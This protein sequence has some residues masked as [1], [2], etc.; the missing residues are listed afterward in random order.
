M[1][2]SFQ[3]MLAGK[4]DLLL[5][6]FPVYVSAKLD[7]VRITIR[8]Q[9]PLTRKLKQVPNDH[10]RNTLRTMKLPDLDGE[11]IVG[12]ATAKDCFNCTQ[13]AVMRQDGKPEFAFHV[14]DYV[15]QAIGFEARYNALKAM[16]LK[17]PLYLVPQSL[18]T[19][20]QTLAGAEEI[21]TSLGYEGIMVR[22]V[23][24]PY[25]FGRSTTAEGW[26]LK[27]KRFEDDEATV[28]G[29][30][31]L[32]HNSNMATKDERG[33]TKRSSH[34]AGMVPR[35]TLGA[36]ICR[37]PKYEETFK[38]GTGF[39]EKMRKWIWEHRTEVLNTLVKYRHQPS[40]AKDKPRFPSYIGFRSQLDMS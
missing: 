27:L 9:E 18:I 20:K 14:F 10:V 19:S 32:F 3:P 28:I 24:G 13:S 5:L 8:D 36:L 22:S 7:G 15:D 21:A 4:V 29:F 31:E 40:G 39:D 38:I 25:K 33:H 37:S 2:K 35:G 30:E 26:L 12:D 23:N 34:Q 16:K 17:P 6:R 1:G 11:I